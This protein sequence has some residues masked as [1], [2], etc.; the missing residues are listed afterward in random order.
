MFLGVHKAYGW[1]S[2]LSFM[3]YV[4]GKVHKAVNC[5][6]YFVKISFPIESTTASRLSTSIAGKHK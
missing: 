2:G 5:Y 1:V 4:S 6:G 3:L